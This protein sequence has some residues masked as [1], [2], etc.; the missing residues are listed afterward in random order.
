LAK[1]S[2]INHVT[3][4]RHYENETLFWTKA[5]SVLGMPQLKMIDSEI[6]MERAQARL[7]L[8]RLLEDNLA[9]YSAP[10]D[11]TEMIFGGW[12]RLCEAFGPIFLEKSPHHLCQW[13]SL[14]L[15]REAIRE[16][17]S[18]DFLVIGLVRNPLDTVY[19]QYCRWGSRPEH[20]QRQW[21]A[22][23]DNLLRLKALLREK[24][25]IL[26]YEDMVSDVTHFQAILQFCGVSVGPG[27]RDYMHQHA[28]SKWK[29]DRTFGF[30]LAEETMRIAQSFGYAEN[31][32]TNGRRLFWPITRE[33]SRASHRILRPM[34]RSTLRPLRA[35]FSG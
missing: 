29:R 20:L 22:A 23:Y 12:K 8:H 30:T 9:G 26:R 18:V 3:H 4:T 2:G 13:S 33:W 34:T 14:L 6:P 21:C 35:V 15:I 17:T 31:E 24:L 5:A 7:D 16:L 25:I 19:S 32:L 27:D 1:C 11:D 28:I 10:S